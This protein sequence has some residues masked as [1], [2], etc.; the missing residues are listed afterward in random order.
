MTTIDCEEFQENEKSKWYKSLQDALEKADENSNFEEIFKIHAQML[1]SQYGLTNGTDTFLLKEIEYYFYDEVKHPDPYVHKNEKQKV[2]GEYYYHYSGLDITFGKD[3][4]YGGILIRGVE[5]IIKTKENPIFGP[6]KSISN[7]LAL[8]S[9]YDKNC[10]S[11]ITDCSTHLIRVYKLEN[12]LSLNDIRISTRVGLSPSPYDF[13]FFIENE[14]KVIP[15]IFRKYRFLC[16]ES[17]GDY[18]EKLKV[19]FYNQ[20]KCENNIKK[21][22]MTKC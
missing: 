2:A 14:K 22:E 10:Y 3:E 6:I 17:S 15:F 19:N 8:S 5:K 1:M 13:K 21:P 20:A 16:C 18:R 12:N 9:L 4:F 11:K 7:L